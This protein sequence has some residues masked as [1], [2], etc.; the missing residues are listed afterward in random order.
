MFVSTRFGDMMSIEHSEIAKSL[1]VYGEWRF[2]QLTYLSRFI[3]PGDVVIDLGAGTGTFTRAFSHLVGTRGC[4]HAHEQDAGSNEV[5]TRNIDLAPIKNIHLLAVGDA[6]FVESESEQQRADDEPCALDST[7]LPLVHLIRIDLTRLDCGILS[8]AL[9]TIAKNRPL[10]FCDIDKTSNADQIL[11]FS[12]RIGYVPYVVSASAYNRDNH[13]KI[14]ENVFGDA[15]DVGLMLVPSERSFCQDFEISSDS[16]Q[17]RRV[18][19]A[20]ELSSPGHRGASAGAAEDPTRSDDRPILIAVSFYRTPELVVFITDGLLQLIEELQE[21]RCKVVIYNDSPDHQPL[22]EALV[23]AKRKLSPLIECD[24][25]ENP[26]NLGFG[27]TM[28]LAMARAVAE[29]CDILMLNSDAMLSRG[30]L[31]EIR[32]VAYLDPMTGFVCPRSNNAT[33]ATI[34][35]AHVLQA[36]DVVGRRVLEQRLRSALRYLPRYDYVPTAVGFCLFIKKDILNCFGHFSADYGSG[37]N[38]ENDY[39]MRAGRNG[40]RA[41]LANWA[42]AFHVGEQ[43]FDKTDKSRQ[44]REIINRKILD[45][46][47]PEYSG[48]IAAYFSSDK[49]RSENFLDALSQKRVSLAIDL[50]AVF[51]G[52]NGTIFLIV[53]IVNQ[54]VHLYGH[55]LDVVLVGDPRAL[56]YHSLLSLKNVRHVE[57]DTKEI[58]DVVLRIGQPFGVEALEFAAFHAPVNIYFMLDTIAI[59]CCHL[60]SAKL[61]AMWEHVAEC[62]DGI[63]YNSFFT[64]RQF[65]K[66][67]AVDSK[68]TAEIVSYH[69]LDTREYR[70]ERENGSTPSNPFMLII[71]N[72]FP[73][74]NVTP[75][76]LRLVEA[77]PQRNYVVV[78]GDSTELQLRGRQQDRFLQSGELTGAEMDGLYRHAD[79]IIFPSY[80]EGFG[81]PIQQALSEC[82]PVFVQNNE[83]NREMAGLLNSGNLHL[84]DSVEALIDLVSRNIGW[85][86]ESTT[87]HPHNWA[88]SAREIV[89]FS[90]CRLNKTSAQ[91][92]TR[93]RRML[94]QLE[95]VGGAAGGDTQRVI[96]GITSKAAL[97]A[98]SLKLYVK[99]IRI[100]ELMFFFSSSKRKRYRAIRTALKAMILQSTR[101]P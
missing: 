25:I 90:L 80:Y 7:S 56:E 40:F 19:S 9:A 57:F 43:S 61:H 2:N 97:I 79:A 6:V 78:G 65:Q 98:K 38:E 31:A 89:E 10:I 12:A 87:I 83:L 69:S 91:T 53:K 62:A 84:Y 94:N 3:G 64:Q 58:F 85:S 68:R 60:Y 66:R 101:S 88:A 1:A 17:S 92:V 54:I 51:R 48:L 63:I 16:V 20:R 82:R 8:G 76:Y 59:D 33:L 81:F 95:D 5:L 24:F 22:R 13:K 55:R 52:Y 32:Q 37:Y 29:D 44:N 34:G 28:S 30:A 74:K 35:S 26:E 14:I 73:H 46:R 77:A 71:G 96:S 21:H 100:K 45:A 67:F 39:I 93:R 36:D 18:E 72:H 11:E 99:L 42:Y 27:A 4:V 49:F 15:A 47:Y 75:T 70:S 41:V 86:T 23:D 50:S